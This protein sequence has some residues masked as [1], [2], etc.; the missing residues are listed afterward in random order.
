M[1]AYPDAFVTKFDPTGSFLIYSTYLGGNGEDTAWSIAIDS[2]GN[3]YI[4]GRT[5]SSDFPVVNPLFTYVGNGYNGFVTKINAE[6]SKLIYST[7]LGSSSTE[8]SAIAADSDGN[9]YVVGRTSSRDFPTTPGAFQT[10]FQSPFGDAYISVL[11]PTGSAFVY[12][13]YLGGKNGFSVGNTI[14]VSHSKNVY[15]TGQTKAPDF[16]TTS[17]AYQRTL[18]GNT[19]AFVT[20]FDPEGR[21]LIYST[22]LG[23][24]VFDNA[25]TGIAVDGDG[26]AYVAGQTWSPDFP[27]TPGAFQTNCGSGFTH[28]CAFVTAIDPVG[29]TLLYSTFLG[30]N[31]ATIAT[32]L[33]INPSN[34]AFV[35]GSTRATDFPVQN[36]LQSSF[37]GGFNGDVFV[38]QL[39]SSGSDV[40]FSSYLGGIDDDFGSAIAVDKFNKIYVTGSTRSADFPTTEGSFQPSIAGGTDA[41]VVKID[42]SVP[43]PAACLSP[44]AWD[45]GFVPVGVNTFK[46]ISL[47]NCGSAGLQIDAIT[48]S[49]DFTQENDCPASL[50][51]GERCTITTYFV[52]TAAERRTGELS[53]SDDAFRSPHVVRLTGFGANS[54]LQFNPR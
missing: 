30:G 27:T 6:G 46:D 49:G 45:F 44:W 4:A 20:A 43:T 16:P 22:Y 5:N 25:G 50:P 28:A 8:A 24:T 48:V 34:E 23:G 51:A 7:Y 47:S 35:V 14:A 31:E 18:P 41:L 11:N 52:P 26:N 2:F 33:V 36:P 13:T 19:G 17:G 38:N 10:S 29:A 32:G 9:A 15:V 37:A 21:S 42:T 39:N 54:I 12:S 1:P 3:A 40:I 53:V